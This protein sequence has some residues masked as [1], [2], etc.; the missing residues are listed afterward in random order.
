MTTDI[1]KANLHA[2]KQMLAKVN[3]LEDRDNKAPEAI[4]FCKAMVDISL[5]EVAKLERSFAERC[6]KAEAK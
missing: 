1:L 3:W 2:M 5:E 4:G 6:E